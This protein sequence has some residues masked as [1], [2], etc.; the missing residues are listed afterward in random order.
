MPV[1]LF[2][3]ALRRSDEGLNG[4]ID[5]SG[6]F[7]TSLPTTAVRYARKTSVPAAIVVSTDGR[8]DYAFLSDEM[9][10]FP[11]IR[12]PGKGSD[13]PASSLTAAFASDRDK[14]SG[15]KQDADNLE[16]DLWLGGRRGMAAKEE[17]IGPGAYGKVLTVL[18]T[19][20]LAEDGNEDADLA[21]SWTPRHRWR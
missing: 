1:S 21:E 5:L 10:E 9:K 11:G 20:F 17:V 7:L 3:A 19:D 14:M 16:L 15:A 13:V 4:I 8:V 2:K 6:K 12:W 18:T